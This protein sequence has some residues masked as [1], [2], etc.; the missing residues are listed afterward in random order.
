MSP[1]VSKPPGLYIYSYSWKSPKPAEY[2]QIKSQQRLVWGIPQLAEH[3]RSHDGK[4]L[5]HR[6]KHLALNG[7]PAEEAQVR[8]DTGLD[9]ED[10]R[11]L[12][13]KCLDKT[14]T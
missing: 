7:E 2:A 1:L 9:G 8:H 6:H 10:E 12:T 4:Q 3:L 5:I 14:F 11:K 13:P